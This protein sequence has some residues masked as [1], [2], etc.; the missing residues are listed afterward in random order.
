MVFSGSDVVGGV[1]DDN[2][3]ALV[4]LLDV[5]DPRLLE[6]ASSAQTAPPSGHCDFCY[7]G[8]L[9]L[10][11]SHEKMRSTPPGAFFSSGNWTFS[12]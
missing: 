12:P 7:P 3:P 6:P 11:L 1:E 2:T 5:D 4:A 10:T 9:F 8:P